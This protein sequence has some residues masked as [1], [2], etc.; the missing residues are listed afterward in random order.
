MNEDKKRNVS[1]KSGE[2]V[3]ELN[4]FYNRF[5]CPD[6]S[7]E[8]VQMRN[9]LTA[10]SAQEDEDQWPVPT[11]KKFVAYF[12]R[13]TKAAGPDRITPINFKEVDM[14]SLIFN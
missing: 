13:H 7:Y 5:D 10:A 12:A 11:K 14:F 4:N 8:N 9:T 6:F 1:Q 2:Y 3:N